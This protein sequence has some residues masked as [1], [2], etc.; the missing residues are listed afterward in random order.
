MYFGSKFLMERPLLPPVY[1]PN[2]SIKIGRLDRLKELG[3]FFGDKLG[4]IETPEERSVH[5]A[6]RFDFDICESLLSRAPHRHV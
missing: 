6:T 2:G 3:H 5:V 1:R 4:T